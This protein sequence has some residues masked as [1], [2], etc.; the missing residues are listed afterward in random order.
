MDITEL[1]YDKNIKYIDNN[2]AGSPSLG[3]TQGDLVKLLKIILVE[4][5]NKKTATSVNPESLGNIITITLPSGHGFNFNQIVNISGANQID[6]N[7]DYRVLYTDLTS[8]KIRTKKVPN[9]TLYFN[10]GKSK[11][12]S[13]SSS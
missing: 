7:S 12:S 9:L 5:F 8:I 2:F 10:D 1:N 4:G 13:S 3:Y 6:F 11:S